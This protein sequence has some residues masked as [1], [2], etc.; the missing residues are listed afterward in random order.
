MLAKF[1]I[2]KSTL[3]KVSPYFVLTNLFQMFLIAFFN[4]IFL[5]FSFL[6]LTRSLLIM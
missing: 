5:G 1:N 6:F 3:S 2:A 4:K